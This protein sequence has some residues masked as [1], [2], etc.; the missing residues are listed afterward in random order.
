MILTSSASAL[1][2][3][4]GLQVA[5]AQGTPGVCDYGGYVLCVENIASFYASTCVPLQQAAPT[6]FAQCVCYRDAHLMLVFRR[7]GVCRGEGEGDEWETGLNL[8]IAGNRGRG[9]L[10]DKF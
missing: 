6:F 1:L 9:A 10:F 5:Q 2:L 8:S 7:G 4:A 3:L